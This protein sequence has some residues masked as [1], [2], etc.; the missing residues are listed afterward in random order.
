MRLKPLIAA[1]LASLC[2]A[3][4]IQPAAQADGPPSPAPGTHLMLDAASAPSL[5]TVQR[6]QQ[7]SPYSAIAVYLPVNL[8]VDNRHDKVQANLTAD[9]VQAVRAGGWQVLPIY[10]GLQ[11]PHKCDSGTFHYL[12][13]DATKAAQQGRAAAV[14]AVGAAQSLGITAG[15][16][17]VYDMEAYASGC[18][19]AMRAFYSAWTTKLHALGRQSGIYGSRNSTITDV[20]ALPGHGQAA[21][22]AVWVATASG[23][24]QTAS[25]PPLPDGTWPGKRLNQFNLGVTRSYGGASVNIDESAVDDAVWDTTAPTIGLPAQANATTRSSYLFDWTGSDTGG[26]GVAR[27]EI[28]TKEAAFGRSLGHWSKPIKLGHSQRRVRLSSGEQWCAQVRATDHAGNRSHWS[29]RTCT[30][31]FADDRA[32]HAAGHWRR[33]HNGSAYQH[34]TTVARHKGLTLSTGT[35]RFRSIGVLLHGTGTVDV[36]IG[37]RKV[38]TLSGSGLLWLHLSSTHHGVLRLRTVSH[39]KV[40]VDGL[41][42]LGV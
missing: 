42:L 7:A 29:R 22:D 4:L 26:S 31:R 3:A 14:D 38:G 18:S 24:A 23:Q 12:S 2:G 40:A 27:Y 33:A 30:A 41:A 28:R 8:R 25:L 35:A 36:L 19:K 15:A 6:W 1:A 13:N 21:P 32:L 9:W 37:H 11:A 16:P 39:A 34:T 10:V 5:S 20:A 17:I